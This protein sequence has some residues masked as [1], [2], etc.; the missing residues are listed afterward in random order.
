VDIEG[1]KEREQI[2]KCGPTCCLDDKCARFSATE[3]LGPWVV[4][5][6]PPDAVECAGFIPKP[7]G[8]PLPPPSTDWLE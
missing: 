6:A 2:V 3:R 8:G 4:V 1:Q 7:G 5:F